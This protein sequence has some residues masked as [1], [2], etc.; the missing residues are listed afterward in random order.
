MD[1]PSNE[2]KQFDACNRITFVANRNLCSIT[3]NNKIVMFP[4]NEFLV[5]CVP[6][7]QNGRFMMSIEC[8]STCYD[9]HV[10]FKLLRIDVWNMNAFDIYC[11]YPRF[12]HTKMGLLVKSVKNIVF[13]WY[14]KNIYKIFNFTAIFEQYNNWLSA[15]STERNTIKALWRKIKCNEFVV[16]AVK[17][18]KIVIIV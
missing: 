3:S 14:Q 15:L 4:F 6:P 2:T 8:C 5:L 17:R 10:A 11:F 18:R 13:S 1:W 7:H 16:G 9:Q 12:E